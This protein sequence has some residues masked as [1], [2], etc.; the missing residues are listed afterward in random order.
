MALSQKQLFVLS[1]LEWFLLLCKSSYLDLR[2]RIL[3]FSSY[4][5]QQEREIKKEFEKIS[6]LKQ[7]NKQ[8]LII[9]Q[10][11]SCLIIFFKADILVFR[12]NY[13]WSP[14]NSCS[15]LKSSL[16]IL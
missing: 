12:L 15:M 3:L 16:V 1:R 5:K 4:M 10:R 2:G 11:V 8:L 13:L 6:K 9:V 14:Q 7:I